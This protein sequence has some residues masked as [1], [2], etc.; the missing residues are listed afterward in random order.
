MFLYPCRDVGDSL[1]VLYYRVYKVYTA[2]F[3]KFPADR[4]PPASA[5]GT[6]HRPFEWNATGILYIRN[7]RIDCWRC[8]HIQPS[9]NRIYSARSHSASSSVSAADA[10]APFRRTAIPYTRADRKNTRRQLEEYWAMIMLH[11]RRRMVLCLNPSRPLL[12]VYAW[13]IRISY[14]INLTVHTYFDG[15]NCIRLNK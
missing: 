11:S 4:S 2:A 12:L 3:I 7:F 1:L 5:L 14:E 6:E 13:I 9:R 15:N 8:S 10:D